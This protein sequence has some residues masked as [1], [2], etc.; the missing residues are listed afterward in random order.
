MADSPDILSLKIAQVT[1]VLEQYRM[2][3]YN[4]ELKN[5]LL[6]KMLEEK[7]IMA[8]DEF[9]KRWPLYLKNNVGIVG[10]DGIMEG[11]LKVHF[12]GEKQ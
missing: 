10:A 5:N 8:I 12:W 3:I 2:N 4:L 1:Q 6:I 11:N 9:E 7:G